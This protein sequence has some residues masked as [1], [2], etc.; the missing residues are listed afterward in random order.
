MSGL[1]AGAWG[2]KVRLGPCKNYDQIGSLQ[3]GDP[4]VL[5][6]RFDVASSDYPW[7]D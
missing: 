4:V 1:E 6:K 2:G 7:F 3:N 5:L